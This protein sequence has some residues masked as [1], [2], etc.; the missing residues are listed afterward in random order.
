LFVGDDSYIDFNEPTDP[1]S[2]TAR[3]LASAGNGAF[4]LVLEP[5]DFDAAVG[6]L[7]ERAVPTVTREPVDLRVVWR[8]G[9]T[10]SAARIISLDRAFTCGARIFVSEPTFPW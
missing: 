9:T 2:P 7:Q 1:Q 3:R 4:A 6:A 10:G 5:H 8:D